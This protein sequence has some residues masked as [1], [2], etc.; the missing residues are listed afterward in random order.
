M[1]GSFLLWVGMGW[2]QN[3]ALGKLQRAQAL[4]DSLRYQEAASLAKGVLNNQKNP[5]IKAQALLLLGDIAIEQADLPK[6]KAFFLSSLQQLQTFQSKGHPLIAQ[7]WNNLG[8]YELKIDNFTQAIQWHQNALKLRIKLFG[9]QHEKTADSYNNMG[10]CQLKLGDYAGARRMHQQALHIRKAVLPP[11]H[12]DIAVSHNNLGNCAYFIGDFQEAALEYRAALEIREKTFGSNHLKITP[13]LNNLG[14][15]LHEMG[16]WDQAQAIFEKV[17]NIRRKVYGD[18]DP[19]LAP[20]FENIGEVLLEKG[21][22]PASIPYLQQAVF[23]YGGPKQPASASAW[24]KIGLC[25]QRLG[26]YDR[27]VHHHLDALG[28]IESLYGDQVYAA[29]IYSNIGVCY[30]QKK[31]YALSILNFKIAANKLHKNL[32]QGHPDLAQIHNSMALGYIQQGFLDSASMQSL[33]AL[34]ALQQ[35]GQMQGLGY[36]QV[37]RTRAEILL[38]QGIINESSKLLQEALT[39]L[40]YQP[41]ETLWGSEITMEVMKVLA[42]QGRTWKAIA[43]SSNAPKAVLY[44]QK[45]AAQ[46]NL[47]A[48]HLMDFLRHQLSS[49]GARQLWLQQQ[50]VLYREATD[51]YF[52]IWQVSGQHSYLEKAF[53][54]SEKS[55]GVQLLEGIQQSQ[56][57]AQTTVPKSWA[58]LEQDLLGRLAELESEKITNPSKVAQLDRKMLEQMQKLDSLQKVIRSWQ[59]KKGIRTATDTTYSTS[60]LQK[61]LL[62]P[63]QALV[64]YFETESSLLVFVLTAQGLKGFA[65]PKS[66]SLVQEAKSFRQ[67]LRK[68]P[69][70]NGAA[71]D[72][73]LL[74]WC[75]LS[76]TLYQAIFK[77]L[78]SALKGNESLII[79]ADGPLSYLPFESLMT[80]LPKN[81]SHFKSHAYLLHQYAIQYSYSGSLS[82]ELSRKSRSHWFKPGILSMAPDFRGHGL[83]LGVLYNN[84]KEAEALGDLWGAKVL[85]GRNA[86]LA[87]FQ[88]FA[89][90]YPILHLATHGKYFINIDNY[91]ALAFVELKDTISNEYLYTR[92]LYAMRL[93][94]ELVVLSACETGIGDYHS[95][96]GVI[97]L[98]HGFIHAGAKSVVNTLW[99]VDDARTAEL[100]VNFFQL[101]KKGE[102]RD[103]ALQQAKLNLLENRPHDEVHPYFWAGLIGIGATEAVY[104]PWGKYIGFAG[105]LCLLLGFAGVWFRYLKPR[106]L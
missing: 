101:L 1:L 4:F 78:Q 29:T 81:T 60:F 73:N 32:L 7:A 65:L 34:R 54:L 89:P 37:L 76:N 14:K 18:T 102:N 27:A 93:P 35:I 74:A 42:Q 105:I 5:E 21:D 41:R 10:N 17:L 66:Q 48:L 94:T 13:A 38:Q 31:R 50:Y 15:V 8:E 47:E 11:N 69:A 91:S 92:D 16:Q 77:P 62:K 53:L 2:G 3:Q 33:L 71:L 56:S 106:F 98:A 79:V 72:S 83:G 64:E 20:T 36:S 51:L 39:A 25:H 45:K 104:D 12:T 24:H 68:Y 23:L 63:K 70:L 40:D 87:A 103:R 99:S 85:T 46:A 90:R 75:Q 86:T 97:S 88:K 55:K 57:N 49:L 22:Y 61:H 59:E 43:L 100:V 96:E 19:T 95:G 9:E 80:K 44:W 30:L 84:Q 26:D 82:W 6:A 28:P 52:R 58:K 67:L